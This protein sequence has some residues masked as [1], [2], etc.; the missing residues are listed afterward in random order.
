MV[1]FPNIKINLG[2]NVVRRRN[3]G[4]HDIDTV[5]L[6]VPFCDILEILPNDNK[7][8]QFSQSGLVIPGDPEDNL[9]MKAYR[10]FTERT[11]RSGARIHL[12]K[13]IPPGS[14]LGGGSSDGAFT[15]AMLNDVL[16]A[17]LNSDE[18]LE[19]ASQLGSDCP[20]FISNQPSH[21]TGRGETLEE[22]SI[23]LKDK[24][25]FLVIPGISISTKWAYSALSPF[26][27]ESS[28]TKIVMSDVREWKG[29]LVN[30]F[31]MPV[32]KEYPVI[33]EI[34]DRLYEL[35]AL[36]A[37]MSGSGSAVYGIFEALPDKLAS[38]FPDC[39]FWH[40]SITPNPLKGAKN[41]SPL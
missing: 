6:P 31:E 26:K 22:M 29:R 7:E 5:M 39:T 36:Y 23:N 17:E 20:F 27:A 24:E 8:V 1:S 9:V 3:D 37:S 40:G 34:R 4:Y 11:G 41:E 30:D 21:A 18:L 33:R 38:E 10:L 16:K 25:I 14:G 35:G 28:P 2:L 19:M 15:L 13:V 32:F 12:H